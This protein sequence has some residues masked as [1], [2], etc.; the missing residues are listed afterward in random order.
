MCFLDMSD[1]T[2][3]ARFS[4]YLPSLALKQ[5]NEIKQVTRDVLYE[6]VL[7]KRIA[8]KSLLHKSLITG[9]V[10]LNDFFSNWCLKAF[11]HCMIIL[12]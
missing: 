8:R 4:V 7:V 5:I 11:S 10:F 1:A 6:S 12:I 9:R 3:V 2:T